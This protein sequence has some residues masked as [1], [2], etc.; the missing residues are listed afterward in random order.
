MPVVGTEFQHRHHTNPSQNITRPIF[1][2]RVISLA[3]FTHKPTQGMNRIPGDEQ[4]LGDTFTTWKLLEGT[5]H[6]REMMPGLI[7]GHE[8]TVPGVEVWL[9]NFVEHFGV[10]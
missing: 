6:P 1:H 5:F 2:H 3:S 9:G 10:H 4:V 8:E 7:I